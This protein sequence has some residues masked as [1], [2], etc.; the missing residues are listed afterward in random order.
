MPA[1]T[2]KYGVIL[3]FEGFNHIVVCSR[4]NS[5]TFAKVANAL[6]MARVDLQHSVRD[7]FL[8]YRVQKG[9]FRYAGA[10]V[11]F[12]LFFLFALFFLF[13]LSSRKVLNQGAA[14]HHVDELH[15][16]ANRQHWQFRLKS[17]DGKS[18]L[19][20]IPL[21]VRRLCGLAACLTISSRIN[22]SPS[23]Q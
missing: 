21:V 11:L 10:Q 4:C 18:Y 13:N 12:F 5:Q 7:D 22:I 16:T 6:M 1:Y 15:S 9:T 23:H 20:I 2:E 8:H 3:N 19:E 17:L 14:T